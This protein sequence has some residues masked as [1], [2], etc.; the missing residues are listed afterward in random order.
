M[1]S[2]INKYRHETQTG[3]SLDCGIKDADYGPYVALSVCSV[4]ANT[5]QYK[6]NKGY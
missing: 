4:E 5:W 1:I 3:T 2:D 6:K